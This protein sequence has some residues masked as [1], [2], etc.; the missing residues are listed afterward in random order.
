[1]FIL[2]EEYLILNYLVVDLCEN[3]SIEE[4][5]K[6]SD[7]ALEIMNKIKAFNSERI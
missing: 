1:M 6:F 7:E 4:G 3:S 5:L 2:K